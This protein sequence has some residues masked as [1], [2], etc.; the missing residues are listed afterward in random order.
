MEATI[1]ILFYNN[2]QKLVTSNFNILQPQSESLIKEFCLVN[3]AS[4]DHTLKHL[5]LVQK[6]NSNTITIVDIK[7]KMV[8]QK[9]VKAS[10]RYLEDDPDYSMFFYIDF[11]EFLENQEEIL[12]FFNHNFITQMNLQHK[13]SRILKNTFSLVAVLEEYYASE[14]V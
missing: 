6:K 12:T 9:V 4:S 2:E 1:I 10:L 3:N 5:K 11:E 8:L 7:K 14:I 13:K